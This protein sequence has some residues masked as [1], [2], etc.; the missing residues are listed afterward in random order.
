MCAQP[1]RGPCGHAGE[2]PGTRALPARGN[3][4]RN[5]AN[6]QRSLPKCGDLWRV[7]AHS[8][9]RKTLKTALKRPQDRSYESPLDDSARPP[10]ISRLLGSPRDADRSRWRVWRGCW[11]YLE[12]PCRLTRRLSGARLNLSGLQSTG[13]YA[14]Y[15]GMY[16]RRRGCF[17]L[18]GPGV[19][20]RQWPH[21]LHSS[22]YE[23][24]NEQ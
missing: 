19:C 4:Q 11:R 6:G 20:L 3:A 7:G 1:W 16:V 14:R 22:N 23:L 12:S 17:G 15:G 9:N 21:S 10:R 2:R 8:G 24:H 13:E 18:V 5:P